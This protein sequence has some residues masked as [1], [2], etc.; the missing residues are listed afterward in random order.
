LTK[1]GSTND[2]IVPVMYLKRFGVQKRGGHSIQAAA[3]DEP[4]TSFTRNVHSV[5]AER[6]FYWGVG[7]DGVPHHHMEELLGIIETQAAPAFRYCLETML[8]LIDGQLRPIHGWRCLGGLRPRYSGLP[9]KG[10]GCGTYRDQVCR[11]P[12]AFLGETPTWNIY[13]MRWVL[14]RP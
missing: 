3:A 2:H 10:K 13:W 12:G 9:V 6:G 4:T 14:L 7:A 8:F 11:F 5:A 1:P